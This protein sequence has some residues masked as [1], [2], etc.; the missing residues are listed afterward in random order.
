[1]IV[2]QHGAFEFT[3]YDSA[4][5]D[6]FAVEFRSR[7]ESG[8]KFVDVVGFGDADGGAQIRGLHEHREREFFGDGFHGPGGWVSAAIAIENDP[9]DD[10]Q[11]FFAADALH[12]VL[13]HRNGGREHVAA[14]VGKVGELEETLDRAV[15]T[16]RAMEDGEY[17]IDI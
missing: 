6:D 14:D 17:D 4:L 16:E 2:P 8:A 10:G 3:A 5:D 7:F 1:M 9:I 11:A 15:F 13:V 12:H